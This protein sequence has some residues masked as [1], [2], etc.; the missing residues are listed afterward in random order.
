MNITVKRKWFTNESTIGELYIDNVFQCYTLEDKDREL[1]STMTTADIGKIKV[2]GKTAIPRGTY[3]I[4]I[5]QTGIITDVGQRPIGGVK[6]LPLINNIKGYSGVFTH[7]GNKAT[8]TEGCLLCGEGKGQDTL[9]S[10]RPA[11]NKVFDKI[12]AAAGANANVVITYLKEVVQD[13]RTQDDTPNSASQSSTTLDATQSPAEDNDQ[14]Q[15]K[16]VQALFDEINTNQKNVEASD[17]SVTWGRKSDPSE[18]SDWLSLKQFLLYLCTRYA[19]QTV[20]PFI[21]LIPILS[22]DQAQDQQG[23]KDELRRLNY[24]VDG[25]TPDQLKSE[26][27]KQTSQNQTIIKKLLSAVTDP[28]PP[29][30]D[31]QRFNLSAKR[32]NEQSGATDLFGIDPW[33]EGYKNLTDFSES[34]QLVYSKR[35]IGLRLYGQL[36]LTPEPIAGVPSKPGGIGFTEVEIKA[37]SQS[38]NGLAMI[39]LKLLD[40]QGNKFT[41][42]NSPWA[43]IFDVRPGSQGGDFFFRYG[44]E[45]ALPDPGTQAMKDN[46]ASQQF[47]NHPG[48]AIF[49]N[50][51]KE[52]LKSKLLGPDFKIYLTQA[53][54]G[55]AVVPSGSEAP[56]GQLFAPGV[57][58]KT[59]TGEILVSKDLLEGQDSSYVRLSLLN[60]ELSMDSTSGAITAS[61]QFMTT[62]ALVQMVPVAYAANMRAIVSKGKVLTLAELIVAFE[63]D[64]ISFGVLDV[65][66]PAKKKTLQKIAAIKQSNLKKLM[67]NDKLENLAFVTGANP[68]SSV[69]SATSRV[70]PN[71]VIIK[72]SKDANNELMTPDADRTKTLLRWFRQVLED[73]E[74]VL[75][76]TATGSGAGINAA[77][78]ITTT[79]NIEENRRTYNLTKVDPST[80]DNNGFRDLEQQISSEKDV[81]AFRF[82]GSL[83]ESIDISKTDAPNS[84]TITA[85][86]SLNN[87]ASMEAEPQSNDTKGAIG[88]SAVTAADRQRNLLAL[89]AQMQNVRVNAIAHPWLGPG[90]EAFIKGMGFFDG[91][92]MILSIVHRL[93]KHKFTSE[94]EAVR[95]LPSSDETDKTNAKKDSQA[96]GKGNFAQ[97]VTKQYAEDRT[98]R[99]QKQNQQNSAFNNTSA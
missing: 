42:I 52:D 90:Q 60:P 15:K 7:V 53:V 57:D 56:L 35:A 96:N 24:D 20:L 63:T 67:N 23:V 48:W 13:T 54:N 72:I 41:D 11:F 37:G 2:F 50:K 14:K 99:D 51:I 38:D 36:V 82:Q 81:F 83:V 97:P 66:N 39:T 64:S 59:D 65:D 47:W 8:H 93:V 17:V 69:G 68:G 21:E 61:L 40:V 18:A 74:C 3:P 75:L 25:K 16:N 76:S 43:F 92:Y 19:Q 87:I 31:E 12:I 4:T 6:K 70:N 91:K 28:L 77:Y 62:G 22:V 80:S 58:Y 9:I 30:F 84:M 78:V 45:L 1:D 89:Y 95:M 79:Q 34:G 5:S 29:G 27:E 32:T 94:I 98:Q 71:E 49:D 26:Y 10:S 88:P 85:N 46:R 44:W 73:N 55:P 86:N 33:K